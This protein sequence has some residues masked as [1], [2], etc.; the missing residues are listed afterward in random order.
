MTNRERWIVYPLL[1]FA[2]MMG[3]RS[4]FQNPLLVRARSIECSD[5]KVRTINGKLAVDQGVTISLPMV[6]RA[7]QLATEAQAV[8]EAAAAETDT[9][10]TDTAETGAAETDAA[11]TDAAETDAADGADAAGQSSEVDATAN[12]ASSGESL[13]SEGGEAKS[14]STD[15][16]DS[17]EANEEPGN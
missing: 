6:D 9:A 3:M 1:A 5:L 12:S 14:E 17:A 2:L 13:G 8:I 10:E 7:M 11:E 4:H 16:T 15:D